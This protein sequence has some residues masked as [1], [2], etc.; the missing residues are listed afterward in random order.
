MN[1]LHKHWNLYHS[2]PASQTSTT[3]RPYCGHYV[4]IRKADG[5][6][7]TSKQFFM[8][9]NH[10]EVK[11]AQWNAS[12]PKLWAYEAVAMPVMSIGMDEIAYALASEAA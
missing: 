5:K 11:L 12:L 8:N 9:A 10:F 1:I 7:V 6:R 3:E 4:L 2:E